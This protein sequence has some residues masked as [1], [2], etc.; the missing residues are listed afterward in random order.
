METRNPF[1]K[2]ELEDYNKEIEKIHRVKD[3][4][5]EMLQLLKH[6]EES[7]RN[8]QPLHE[9]TLSDLRLIIAKAEGRV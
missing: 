2:S 6:I 8:V 1:S 9:D 4:A 3:V 7:V 5:L